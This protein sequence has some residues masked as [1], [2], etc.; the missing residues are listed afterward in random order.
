MLAFLAGSICG[1]AAVIGTYTF[2]H[3]DTIVYTTT[4]EVVAEGIAIPAGTELVHHAEMA[5]GFDT[6]TLFLNVD[7]TDA[8][9]KFTKRVD[10]RA[11]LARPY[12]VGRQRAR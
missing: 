8:S 6:L 2:V 9:G 3:R 7:P 1:A 10:D 4:Q 5:E 11:F 12:W